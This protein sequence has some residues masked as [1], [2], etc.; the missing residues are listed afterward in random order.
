MDQINGDYANVKG[1]FFRML[2]DK[3]LDQLPKELFFET[4]GVYKWKAGTTRLKAL[5]ACTMKGRNQSG[6]EFLAANNP[7]EHIRTLEY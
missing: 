3:E 4:E 2:N 7:H 5:C 1:T 6:T